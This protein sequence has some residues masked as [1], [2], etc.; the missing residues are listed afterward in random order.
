MNSAVLLTTILN[1]EELKFLSEFDRP[2]FRFQPKKVRVNFKVR[3]RPDDF[4][5]FIADISA[6]K[7]RKDADGNDMDDDFL[8]V[9]GDNDPGDDDGYDN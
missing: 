2:V 3:L 1:L 4:L 5:D 6:F 9:L 8:P 7:L